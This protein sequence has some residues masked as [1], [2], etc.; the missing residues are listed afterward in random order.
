MRWLVRIRH[1]ILTHPAAVCFTLAV[2]VHVVSL[3]GDRI[4]DDHLIFDQDPYDR[5]REPARY[6]Q[7]LTLDYHGGS[8]NLY[9]P[10]GSLSFALGWLIWGEADWPNHVVNLL[11]HGLNA[12]L[13]VTLARRLKLTAFAALAAGALF[14]VHPVHVEAVVGLVGRFE[15]GCAAGTLGALVLATKPITRW[16]VAGI[17]GCWVVALGCNEQGLLVPGLVGLLIV[18]TRGSVRPPRSG[19]GAALIA[20]FGLG[21]AGY[22]FLKENVLNLPFW[23]GRHFLS[24]NVQPLLATPEAERPVV[25]VTYVGRYVGL[26][27]WPQTLSIDWGGFVLPHRVDVGDPFLW[28]GLL[29]LAVFVATS[30]WAFRTRRPT[31]LL[32]LGG[33]GLTYSLVSNGFTIIGVHFAERLVYLP[34]AFVALLL[35]PVLARVPWRGWVLIALV[36]GFGARSAVY[37]ERWRDED[38]FYT[39]SFAERPTMRL[40]GLAAQAA[41]RRGEL[42]EAHRLAT[43]ATE[44]DGRTWKPWLL[45]AQLS[46]ELGEYE[47]AMA[48]ARAAH[49]RFPAAGGE[50]KAAARR[51]LDAAGTIEPTLSD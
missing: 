11:L 43:L 39:E 42:E 44:L 37:A 18:A 2:L 3:P 45:A 35:G 31:V 36:V 9:R 29:T 48:E 8:D 26:A 12:A 49:A 46:L 10:L 23:F 47:R 1:F 28:L 22:V 51:A 7:Y 34:S 6:W 32:L 24:V 38:T 33:L 25:A 14:A 19:P 17:V 20:A 15:L 40:A 30:L 27:V 21:T 41:Q 4:Y 13:V 50:I 5:I 16:R